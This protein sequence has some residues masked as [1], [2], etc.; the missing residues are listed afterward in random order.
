MPLLPESLDDLPDH[1]LMDLYSEFVSWISYAKAELALAEVAEEE[2]ESLVRYAEST[3]LIEQWSSDTKGDR[4]TVA[5]AR[6]DASPDV[7]AKRNAHLEAR[8]YRKLVETMFDRCDRS[9][10]VLSRELSRRIGIASKERG[11]RYSA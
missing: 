4:V 11:N 9:A 2:A 6:R 3:S 1:R 5:K 7:I 8:A 10:Q